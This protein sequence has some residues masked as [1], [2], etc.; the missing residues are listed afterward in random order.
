MQRGILL[1][2]M[3]KNFDADERKVASVK[4]EAPSR[5]RS[6]GKE[7][8]QIN[9]KRKKERKKIRFHLPESD[10]NESYKGNVWLIS[11]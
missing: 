5:E 3:W 9:E 4:D 7:E 2:N 11:I 8:T 10:V 1:N 6:R